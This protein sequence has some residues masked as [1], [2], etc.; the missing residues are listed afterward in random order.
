MRTLPWKQSG[1]T[2]REAWIE[3]FRRSEMSRAR[4]VSEVTYLSLFGEEHPRTCRLSSAGLRITLCGRP[5]R[6]D[7][8]PEVYRDAVGCEEKVTYDPERPGRILV[9]NGEGLRFV[10]AENRPM[11]MVLADRRDGD[12]EPLGDVFGLKRRRREELREEALRREELLERARIDAQS[13]LQ[14][15]RLG[16]EERFA[17]VAARFGTPFCSPTARCIPRAS[18]P[19]PVNRPTG[20]P[21]PTRGISIRSCKCC[22]TSSSE[23]R[24]DCIRRTVRSDP[25]T[26]RRRE[27]ERA[28]VWRFRSGVL[29]RIIAHGRHCAR[30][31]GAFP[32]LFPKT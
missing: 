10:A 2:R 30:F 15:G 28:A 26:V 16:K 12:A 13:F 19:E 29:R 31:P 20:R 21:S 1:L 8:P 7:I 27:A 14:A 18:V 32:I 6:Y 25:D 17:A 9:G 24:R 3:G 22:C 4:S 23:G 5:R 11:P